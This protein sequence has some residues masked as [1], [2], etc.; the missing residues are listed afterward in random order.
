MRDNILV[1]S[2]T[3]DKCAGNWEW[4]N[5]SQA[6]IGKSLFRV[7][8][9]VL[10]VFK[11]EAAEYQI[12]IFGFSSPVHLENNLL[13]ITLNLFSMGNNALWFIGSALYNLSRHN[14]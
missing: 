9:V 4:N 1:R 7:V 11:Q 8:A 5:M 6:L 13:I 10:Q 12:L 14:V 2:T 3:S